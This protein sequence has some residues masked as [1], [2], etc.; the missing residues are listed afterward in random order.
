VVALKTILAGR[1]ASADDRSRFAAEALAAARLS[2][3]GIVPIFEVGEAAGQPFF[4]MPLVEGESLAERL[5]A[6][7]LAPQVAARLLLK[8]AAAVTYAHAHGII[9]RDLKPGNILLARGEGSSVSGLCPPG[10]EDCEPKI[11]DFGLAK[12]IDSSDPLTATGQILGT[13]S[14]MA[15][16]QAGGRR[17][18]GP[19]ADVYALGAI[20]YAMLT[21]VPP[22]QAENPVELILNVIEREPPLPSKLRRGLPRELEAICMKCLEKNPLDRYAS[23]ADLAADLDR[24]LRREPLQARR[25][26]PAQ[27]LRRWMRRQP[28]LAWHL[29]ALTSL[30]TLTQVIYAIKQHDDMLYHLRISGALG[31]WMLACLAFQWLMQS[32]RRSDWPHYAWSATDALMLTGVLA[33]CEGPLGPLVGSYLMLICTAGLFFRT[34]LVV[35]TTASVMLSYLLLLV[36]RPEECRPWHYALLFQAALAITGLLIGYQVWRMSVLREYYGERM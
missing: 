8:V 16:E 11:T 26:S 35:F 29:I 18:I 15:P 6:G 19:A 5:K 28:V 13:P 23:A 1:L 27:W 32:Q 2:H 10:L 7:P 21:G 31:V 14:Y 22:F 9:H 30:L 3:P 12:R 34:R 17:A 36:L 25:P 4:A 24:Y 33:L 20:L